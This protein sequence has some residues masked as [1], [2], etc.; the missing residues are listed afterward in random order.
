MDWINESMTIGSLEYIGAFFAI[1]GSL[2]LALK[3]K[4]HQYGWVLF[5]IASVTLAVF[6]LDQGH[7]AAFV[8]ELVFIGTNLLG[9][10]NWII[11]FKKC[12][13]QGSDE[14]GIK[15]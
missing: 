7:Y 8:M 1:T 6:F 2:W 13:V 3:C 14:L 15:K 4:G 5:L 10:K 11:S 9:I 12:E